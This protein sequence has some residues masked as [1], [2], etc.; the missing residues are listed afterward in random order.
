MRLFHVRMRCDLQQAHV[1]V[2]DP[3]GGRR[4]TRVGQQSDQ[5]TVYF[6]GESSAFPHPALRLDMARNPKL[7]ISISV[8]SGITHLVTYIS[9][10]LP[11]SKDE[12]WTMSGNISFDLNSVN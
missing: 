11:F 7:D 3:R 1:D 8:P 6:P 2:L 4:L 5:L 10:V 9:L 12:C